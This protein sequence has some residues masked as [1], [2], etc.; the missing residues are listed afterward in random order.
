MRW[1]DESQ[2]ADRI[3]KA[4]YERTQ[5]TAAEQAARDRRALRSSGVEVELEGAGED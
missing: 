2:R 4:E 3:L 1:L 5:A